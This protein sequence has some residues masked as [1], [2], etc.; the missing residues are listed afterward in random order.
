MVKESSQDI[1]DRANA[2]IA[3]NKRVMA[4]LD[5]AIKG[6]HKVLED[7]GLDEA[8]IKKLLETAPKEVMEA[9]KKHVEKEMAPFLKDPKSVKSDKNKHD[10]SMKA[11]AK[12]HD[13]QI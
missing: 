13:R 2:N 1:M 9:A 4:D 5:K 10:L 11:K 12:R 8:K 6:Y 7:A 3:H